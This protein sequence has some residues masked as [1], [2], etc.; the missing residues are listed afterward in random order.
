MIGAFFLKDLDAEPSEP[1]GQS[2]HDD[3][4]PVADLEWAR[5]YISLWDTASAAID[6]TLVFSPL[7]LFLSLSITGAGRFGRVVKGAGLTAT[8]LSV[9]SFF[10]T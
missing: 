5:Y 7:Y 9:V 10:S 6:G 3:E 2:A 8:L 4:A 1:C